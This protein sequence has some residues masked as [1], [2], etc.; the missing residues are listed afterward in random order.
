MKPLDLQPIG[1]ELAIRWD[2]G[3]ESFVSLQ[4]L[5]RHCP[6]A[7]CRGEVDVLGQLHKGPDRP[8]SPRSFELVRLVPVGGYGIQPVWGDGHNTGIFAFDFLR[9]L[10]DEG[11]RPQSRG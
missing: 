6:C 9:R 5:R 1:T 10:A 8:L 11:T 3:A 2:D 4:T 7:S